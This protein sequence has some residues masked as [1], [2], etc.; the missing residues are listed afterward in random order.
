MN[1]AISRSNNFLRIKLYSDLMK[2]HTV[3]QFCC[4]RKV[5]GP[6]RMPRLVLVIVLIKCHIVF[7]EVRLI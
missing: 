5:L 7:V 1:E 3:H 6:L 4:L 2:V